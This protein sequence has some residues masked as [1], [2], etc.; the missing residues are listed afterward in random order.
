MPGPDSLPMTHL[1]GPLL[2]AEYWLRPGTFL[3]RCEKPARY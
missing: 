2:A 1:W 3:D